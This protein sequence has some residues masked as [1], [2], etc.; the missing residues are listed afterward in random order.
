M[1]NDENQ[2]VR[3]EVARQRQM[4]NDMPK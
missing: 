4:Q 3:E 2:A 1:E